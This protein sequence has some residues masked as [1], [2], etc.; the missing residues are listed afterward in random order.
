M[1]KISTRCVKS[2]I[3]YPW[4]FLELTLSLATTCYLQE[5]NSYPP[6]GASSCDFY[7]RNGTRLATSELAKSGCELPFCTVAILGTQCHTC[8]ALL[9]EV[10]GHYLEC[11]WLL[12]FDL[13]LETCLC[14]S[15]RKWWWQQSIWQGISNMICREIVS[16]GFGWLGH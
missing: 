15:W 13:L 7:R 9:N 10:W 2:P 4:H 6:V 11:C 14:K 3:S 12:L 1:L 8:K 16:E 5:P